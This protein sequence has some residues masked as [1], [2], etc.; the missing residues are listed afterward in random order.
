MSTR[1]IIETPTAR[2]RRHR[3]YVYIGIAAL[4]LVGVPG[5]FYAYVR[6]TS[7]RELRQVIAETDQL[8]P[9]WRLDDL[10][11]RRPKVPDSENSML[12]VLRAKQ[13][14]PDRWPEW[15]EVSAADYENYTTTLREA[16]TGAFEDLPRPVQLSD[17]QTNLLRAEL[18]RVAPAVV[19]ARK[20]ATMPRGRRALAGPPQWDHL[21]QAR[22]IAFLLAYDVLLRAQDADF[23]GAVTSCLALL[24]AGRAVDDEPPLLSQLVRGAVEWVAADKLERILAQGEPSTTALAVL[25]R[26]F[27]EETT[28]LL[29]VSAWRAERAY[30]DRSLELVEG[31]DA[32]LAEVPDIQ[33]FFAGISEQKENERRPGEVLYARLFP[34]K[35]RAAVLRFMNRCVETA[36]LP[37]L[38]QLQQAAQLQ[39]EAQQDWQLIR[40][41]ASAYRPLVESFG[42][43]TAITRCTLVALALEQY[44]RKHGSWPAELAAL[45]PDFLPEIPADPF[46]GK[47]LRFGRFDQGVV[48]YSVGRNGIDDGGQVE[49]K[50]T[51]DGSVERF[52]DYGIRLWDVEHRRQPPRPMQLPPPPLEMLDP[53]MDP[54]EPDRRHIAAVFRCTE[55]V[56]AIQLYR[57]AHGHWPESLEALVPKYLEKIPSDPFDGKQM[58]YRRWEQGVVV[59]SVGPD[60]IDN[61][62]QIERPPSQ[63]GADLGFRLWDIPPLRGSVEK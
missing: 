30:F 28:E 2:K 39:T 42:R 51:D 8:D 58:R 50:V 29:S 44:R 21:G 25:Q 6:F 7:D 56:R 23:D 47:P 46:D 26:A 60:G 37:V 22:E 18:Q 45:V 40:L 62:G 38:Q 5:G 48:V 16:V 54:Q 4:L 59:Y 53:Q 17:Y 15:L 52:K 10:L 49:F 31:G 33:A 63:Q 36:K 19:E 24:N 9:G 12:Q 32:P 13:L 27:T 61:G 14:L 43:G 35:H 41:G 55:I 20:L 11:A 34:K 57:V 1:A 3:K